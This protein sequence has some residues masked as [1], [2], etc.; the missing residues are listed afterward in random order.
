M[1]R[2]RAVFVFFLLSL[3]I[4]PGISEEI[5][6]RDPPKGW[7]VFQKEILPWDEALALPQAPP[8]PEGSPKIETII[9]HVYWKVEA[10]GSAI[11][12]IHEIRRL[13]EESS[14]E[15]FSTV[16]ESFSPYRQKVHVAR[17]QTILADGSTIPVEDSAIF[18]EPYP[19][20]QDKVYTDRRQLRVVFPKTAPGSMTEWI[21][22]EESRPEIPNHWSTSMF[23]QGIFPT[24]QLKVT[25]DL[26]QAIASQ[27][28]SEQ[29]TLILTSGREESKPEGRVLYQWKSGPLN[30][31]TFENYMPSLRQR[32]PNLRIGLNGD[33][34]NFGNW[35]AGLLPL[36]PDDSVAL[37][38]VAEDWAG[39]ATDARD[40]AASL[41]ERVSSEIRYT[42]LSFGDGGYRPR[43]PKVVL[44]TAYGDCK[45]KANLLRALLSHH[46]IESRIALLQTMDPGEIP[47]QIVSLGSFNH[48][49]LAVD[50]ADAETP[51]FCDPT[52]D[53]APFGLLS[54]ASSG[55]T[56][57]LI[58]G[59]GEHEWTQSPEAEP[60]ELIMSSD[61][62]LEPS[63]G[64]AGW[65]DLKLSG[66][67]G[68]L[69]ARRFEVME[70][71][72][73]RLAE[74]KNKFF[75]FI[76]GIRLIDDVAVPDKSF[77]FH[78][79]YYAVQ[80]RRTIE[81]S[82]KTAKIV[83]PCPS[84]LVT[85]I[86]P[87]ELR[88]HPFIHPTAKISVASVFR[89]PPG[90]ET[91]D[92]P[93]NW[94]VSGT[95]Y[96]MNATWS[97]EESGKL[98]GKITMEQTQK[99]FSPRAFDSF[100]KAVRG[101]AAWITSSVLVT[102]SKDLTQSDNDDLDVWQPDPESLP[103]M[104]SGEGFI[105]LINERYPFDPRNPFDSDHPA[106]RAAFERMLELYPKDD[107]NSQFNAGMMALLS[108]L[109]ELVGEDRARDIAEEVRDLIAKHELFVESEQIAAAELMVAV[110]M[111]EAGDVV[112]A[113]T[114]CE[115]LLAREGLANRIRQATSAVL[116]P[117]IAEAQPARA[118]TLAEDALLSP[119]LP[120]DECCIVVSCLLDCLARMPDSTA[121]SLAERMKKISATYTDIT[122]EL[123]LCYL[124]GPEQ[125][126]YY[127]HHREAKIFYSALEIVADELALDK[128]SLNEVTDF[129]SKIQQVAP[130]HQRLL[131]YLAA[132]PWP[133]LDKVEEGDVLD[134]ANEALDTYGKA[135]WVA[136]RYQLRGL[137]HY[138]PQADFS[139]RISDFLETL[140]EWR[141]EITDK[142]EAATPLPHHTDNLVD[143]LLSLWLDSPPGE[144]YGEEIDAQIAR[145]DF[146]ERTEGVEIA[147]RHFQNLADDSTRPARERLSA[148]DRLA[149]L[150]ESSNDLNA[151]IAA[152]RQ[153]EIF[154]EEPEWRL[155]AII[156]G[157][158]LNLEANKRNEAWR[159]FRLAAEE[160]GDIESF[161]GASQ[162]RA[163]A[164]ITDSDE[165]ALW[166]DRAELWW[167]KW[168][169]LSAALGESAKI[170]ESWSIQK[171]W[172]GVAKSALTKL[173]ETPLTS[174]QKLTLKRQ[175]SR[176]MLHTRW[177]ASGT[178]TA[179]LLLQLARENFPELKLEI[180]A[181]IEA[182][183]G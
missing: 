176:Q 117:L 141:A 172:Q 40:I 23:W 173:S 37:A 66:V 109:L 144:F 61:M 85:Q 53:G 43:T 27:L 41:F 59:N 47:Q 151:Y 62:D 18:I 15:D 115:A 182:I 64:F 103:R 140:D 42:S 129:L 134:N 131:D 154:I 152:L 116:T 80:D 63:G 166:W 17:A 179:L 25:V 95:G 106:R 20:T 101:L 98:V 127:G 50:F 10:D 125:L 79:R 3:L 8:A 67:E 156:Q 78:Y 121:S 160:A 56:L 32:G 76:E 161:P 4:R 39:N 75:Q 90:W 180:S 175:L 137:T 148:M 72:G 58:N 68:H 132:N 9:K 107:H 168:E 84:L 122:D 51:V 83:F 96:N 133:D 19:T 119:I 13:L 110:A 55:R 181:V 24:R 94:N 45:D 105:A 99:E 163:K 38:S 31:V 33:W 88:T 57:L 6:S 81:Q 48:A 35:F 155:P 65:I 135:T 86:G 1:H 111:G 169:I 82:S 108:E 136:A 164:F 70:S 149:A 73:A 177:H 2:N 36:T 92:H 34:S 146:L 71:R 138:G 21:L 69:L 93:R 157:A 11:R 49:I 14:A 170:N 123:A 167:P 46:G 150:A 162:N 171:P 30:A 118:I 100:A 104:P 114:L 74:A 29:D 159:L 178:K 28:F 87:E 120:T 112:T 142:P 26:P 128:N 153:Q 5:I 174:K 113:T 158:Y 165:A 139:E 77:P 52:L 12:V 124:A 7:E 183:E 126:V 22:V 16:T 89:L 44:E 102:R 91:L 54:K 145:G 97:T 143:L 60:L 147:T 130:L